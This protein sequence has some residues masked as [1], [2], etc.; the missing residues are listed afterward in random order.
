MARIIEANGCLQRPTA[1]GA[2]KHLLWDLFDRRVFCQNLECT[3]FPQSSVKEILHSRGIHWSEM[4]KAFPTYRRMYIRASNSTTHKQNCFTQVS[5]H[6]C[7]R[8]TKASTLLLALC[9]Y[10]AFTSPVLRPQ[11]QDS[12]NPEDFVYIGLHFPTGKVNL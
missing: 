8:S 3:D 6:N 4:C 10:Y 2:V 7:S 5:Y 12:K 9:H 11:K 1:S